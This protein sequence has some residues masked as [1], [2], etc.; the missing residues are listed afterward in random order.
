MAE[1]ECLRGKKLWVSFPEPGEM[2]V[3]M[4]ESDGEVMEPV[5]MT[6]EQADELIEQLEGLH[7]DR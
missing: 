7:P 4:I 3:Q 2:S 1:I 5:R 6:P